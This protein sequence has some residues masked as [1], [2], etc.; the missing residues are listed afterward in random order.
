M[1]D[2]CCSIWHSP[3]DIDLLLKPYLNYFEFHIQ[4]GRLIEGGR[5]GCILWDYS[6]MRT[7]GKE[8]A[9]FWVTFQFRNE[10]NTILIIPPPKME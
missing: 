10:Q 3:F 5:W 6:R 2:C 4:Q 9:F 8:D 7:H 1:S